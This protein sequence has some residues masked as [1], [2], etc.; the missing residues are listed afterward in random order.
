MHREVN[1]YIDLPSG[2]SAKQLEVTIT[3]TH[4][5][6][7]IKGNPPYLDKDLAGAV[8][9]SESFWTVGT[10]GLPNLSPLHIV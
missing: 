9:T 7:G 3:P 2:I 10:M 6:V 1:I 8:K 4:L 5:T